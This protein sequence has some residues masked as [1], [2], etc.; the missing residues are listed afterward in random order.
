MDILLYKCT[1]SDIFITRRLQHM[2][3]IRL[4][5]MFN[6]DQMMIYVNINQDFFIC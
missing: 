2:F 6:T 1:Q 5:H 4:Q 3:N